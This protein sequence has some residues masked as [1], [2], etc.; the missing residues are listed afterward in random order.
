[1]RAFD[2]CRHDA[3]AA[4]PPPTTSSR[5]VKFVTPSKVFAMTEDDLAEPGE[6]A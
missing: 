3:R 1:M 5:I 2:A 6:R 4:R